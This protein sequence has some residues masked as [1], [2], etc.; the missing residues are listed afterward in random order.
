MHDRIPINTIPSTQMPLFASL[1]LSYKSLKESTLNTLS[2]PEAIWLS[3][4][5]STSFPIPKTNTAAPFCWRREEASSR[6]VYAPRSFVCFPAVIT[7]TGYKTRT[8]PNQIRKDQF[9]E[10]IKLKKQGSL[11]I[12]C[13]H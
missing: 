12:I 8:E 1:A 7:K 9:S 10:S 3:S 11:G 2:G 6:G 4:E 5:V 13:L